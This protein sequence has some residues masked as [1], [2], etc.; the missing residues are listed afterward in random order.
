MSNVVT[1][2]ISSEDNQIYAVKQLYVDRLIL[3][4]SYWMY[5]FSDNAQ[6]TLESVLR[7]INVTDLSHPR[8]T[9]IEGSPGSGKSTLL[10][11]IAYKWSEGNTD[12]DLGKFHI[13]F[14]INTTLIQSH[15][16][17]I[18][19]SLQ[20]H[21]IFLTNNNFTNI[22]LGKY[23]LF[24]IDANNGEITELHFEHLLENTQRQL[25]MSTTILAVRD[26]Y[27]IYLFHREIKVQHFYTLHYILYKGKENVCE[28]QTSIKNRKKNWQPTTVF[29]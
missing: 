23:V 29:Y 6:L 18:V 15:D 27:S 2:F 21:N 22:L 26:H 7:R 5:F 24:L 12:N 13:V 9:L 3:T 16:N 10:Q 1:Q 17:S 20:R 25:P 14:L 4:L 11:M 19:D 8:H 28:K